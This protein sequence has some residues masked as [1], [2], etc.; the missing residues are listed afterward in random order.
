MHV[1]Y[2]FISFHRQSHRQREVREHFDTQLKE[3][4]LAN[5]IFMPSLR[6]FVSVEVDFDLVLRC[7]II[8]WV[9][10]GEDR[11]VLQLARC[12]SGD[13]TL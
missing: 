7:N 6:V 10:N 13:S 3:Y 2:S 8:T 5:T 9:A 1:F 4:L 12:K 11:G